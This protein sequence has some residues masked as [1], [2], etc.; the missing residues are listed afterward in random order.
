[1]DYGS[2]TKADKV[3][4]HKRGVRTKYDKGGSGFLRRH[5]IFENVKTHFLLKFRQSHFEV[6]VRQNLGKGWWGGLTWGSISCCSTS[7]VTLLRT[8]KRMSL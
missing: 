6:R 5:D 2:H 1:M 8:V 4:C 3:E 7:L